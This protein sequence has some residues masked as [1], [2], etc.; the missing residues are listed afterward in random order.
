MFS[1]LPDGIVL[2]AIL[3]VSL[4]VGWIV[5]PKYFKYLESDTKRTKRFE[6]ELKSIIQESRKPILTAIQELIEEIKQDRNERRSN[7]SD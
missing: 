7:K 5:H 3:V 6:E 1:F 2:I 4:I